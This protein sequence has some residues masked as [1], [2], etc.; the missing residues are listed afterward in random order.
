[1]R[2]LH[3]FVVL[4]HPEPSSFAA[5]LARAAA[6]SLGT[7]LVDLYADGF[8]PRLSAAD[9]TE[10]ATP[11]RLQPMDEQ[12]HASRTGTFAP[13]L[14]P[15]I[16]RLRACD[17][18]VLVQPLWWFSMPAIAKGFIDR[19]FANGVAYDYPG[20]PPWTGPLQDKRVLPIFTSSYAEDD[21]VPGRAGSVDQVLFPILYGTLAY[22]GM[23]VLAPFMAFA[24]NS[25]DG[26]TRAGYLTAL[27]QRL[28]GIAA[29]TPLTLAA[30]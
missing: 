29:E 9:F 2:R 19:V 27:Q 28:T 17:L 10:R 16:D 26:E 22:T 5:A 4:S 23:Q 30:R 20:T 18:L 3:S 6:G 21:F 7:P 24:A 13:D 14:A 12:A 1:M 25:V 11:E 15:Y 8:E